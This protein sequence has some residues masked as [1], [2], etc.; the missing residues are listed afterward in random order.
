MNQD[1]MSQRDKKY[2]KILKLKMLFNGQ[3]VLLKT[4]VIDMN[5]DESEKTDNMTVLDWLQMHLSMHDLMY[6]SLELQQ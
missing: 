2:Q 5:E 1:D 6:Q 4:I 3:L